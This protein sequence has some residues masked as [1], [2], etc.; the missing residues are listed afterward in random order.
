MLAGDVLR[1]LEGHAIE[2][3]RDLREA[4]LEFSAG[5]TIAVIV[6]RDGERLTLRATLAKS[7]G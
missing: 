4:M 7:G 6:E 2:D 5:E 3:R 1:E